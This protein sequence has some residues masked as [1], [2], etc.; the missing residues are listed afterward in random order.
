MMRTCNLDTLVRESVDNARPG[1]GDEE[2]G[3]SLRV[4]VATTR[5]KIDRAFTRDGKFAARLKGA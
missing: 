3:D 1:R 4:A 2:M 5:A